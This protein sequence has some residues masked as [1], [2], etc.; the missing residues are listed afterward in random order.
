MNR[1]E[2]F[3]QLSLPY[4]ISR[5]FRKS[6]YFEENFE[7]IPKQLEQEQLPEKKQILCKVCH[8]PITVLEQKIPVNGTHH[9]IFR[10][11]TGLVFEIGC[12]SSAAGCVNYGTPTLEYTWFSGFT[13]CY[14]FCFNCHLHLGW[15]YQSPSS[16]FY[17][18]ILNNL[19]E[20][21]H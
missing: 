15:C 20:P 5:L 18:L 11:P 2:N 1:S 9:H 4:Q 17:G 21:S 13:W 10:N 19:L 3:L 14:A 7:T 12:F 6:P 16:Y 8:Y